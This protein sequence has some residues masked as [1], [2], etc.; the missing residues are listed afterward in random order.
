MFIGASFLR[1][2]KQKRLLFFF[3]ISIA[4]LHTPYV[5][6]VQVF[7]LYERLYGVRGHPSTYGVGDTLQGY[8]KCPKGHP[9]TVSPRLVVGTLPPHRST[10]PHLSG[11]GCTP[12]VGRAAGSW[13]IPLQ[14][15][16]YRFQ[17]FWGFCSLLLR[18]L[19]Y[20]A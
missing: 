3:Y 1:T 10:H 11:W 20:S 7:A 17:S 13:R 18:W 9:C 5:P 2:D 4:H 8:N 19:I 14:P 6:A 15:Q 12:P 16:P